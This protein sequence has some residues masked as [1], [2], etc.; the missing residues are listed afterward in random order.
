[1]EPRERIAAVVLA[2]GR[3]SRMGGTDKALLELGGETLLAR[4]IARLAPQAADI[5]VSA[6]GDLERFAAFARPIVA[7]R[8]ADYPGPL[9]GILAGLEW[10][11]ANRPEFR[12]VVSMPTDTPFFPLDL[13]GRF[14]AVPWP[15]S[16]LLVARSQS[17]V[18]PVVGLWPVDAAPELAKALG[19]G[20]RKVGDWTKQQMAVEILFPPVEIGGKPVDPF[21]NINRPEDLAEAEALLRTR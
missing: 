6:N 20:M 11:A 17:G 12:Y 2:G 16:T 19:K 7:D 10:V 3:S 8:S 18:H 1:M 9:A 4:A 15:D 21:F 13:V 14:L 5:V